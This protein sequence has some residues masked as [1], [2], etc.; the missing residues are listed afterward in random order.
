MNNHIQFFQVGGS[1]RDLLR[2]VPSK[3]IDFAV[4]APSYVEMNEAIVARGG[5]IFKEHPEFVTTKAKVPDLGAC[6]YVLCRKDGTYTNDGRRPDQVFPGSLAD[7]L[8]RR[9]FTMNAIAR[10]EGGTFIDPYNGR[11]DIEAK[12]IRCVGS[13]PQRM[14]EDSLRMLR[15]IRFSITLGFDLS[16][17]LRAFLS[18][19]ESADLLQNISI[20]RIR[21]E[22]TKCF[23]KDTPQT[24]NVLMF[25]FPWIG[26]HVFSRNIRLTPTIFQA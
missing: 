17:E 6:D 13:T 16:D 20:E 19:N 11:A 4:E 24:L 23:V 15:A 21:E 22:L 1:V 14:R 18:C 12:L 9:D 10:T 25:S 3:D 2:G 8:A 5:T 7:D 26:A